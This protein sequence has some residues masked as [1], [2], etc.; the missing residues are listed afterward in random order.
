MEIDPNGPNNMERGGVV[1]RDY[2]KYRCQI[3]KVVGIENALTGETAEMAI[4]GH[5]E[6]FC[7]KVGEMVEEPEYNAVIGI[8][9]GKGIHFYLTEETAKFHA[10]GLMNFGGYTGEFKSWYDNGLR[11]VRGWLKDGK[12][13]GEYE[14]WHD[15]GK[16]WCHG[17]YKD[18][19]MDGEWE[20]WH[21]NGQRLE[22]VWFKDGEED[23]ECE[24]WHVNGKR[25]AHGWYKDGKA[26]GE[27]EEWH[28]NGQRRRRGWYKDGKKDGK[29][30]ECDE[31]GQCHKS[32]WKN[33]KRCRALG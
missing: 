27:W 19:E 21:E 29:W 20:S 9:C 3:A 33:G 11:R 15:N 17:W 25:S 7:Y 32:E 28:E 1:H 8:A 24:E 2:A 23:G 10:L 13:N 30:E 5:D 18:G 6:R 14:E 12:W 4:S 22:R 16:R 26:V 31:D